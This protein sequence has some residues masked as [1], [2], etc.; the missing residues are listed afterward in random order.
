MADVAACVGQHQ[1]FG[2]KPKSNKT[3]LKELAEKCY[4]H[5]FLPKTFILIVCTVAWEE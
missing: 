2:I 5:Y 3:T 1:Q 4:V